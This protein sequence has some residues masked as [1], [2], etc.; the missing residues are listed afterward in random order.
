MMQSKTITS[1]VQYDEETGEL[2]LVI[3]DKLLTELNWTIN[4]TLIWSDN[5]DGSFTLRRKEDA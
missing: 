5:E 4:D 3:P 1:E 2:I